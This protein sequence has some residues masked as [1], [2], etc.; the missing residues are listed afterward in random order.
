MAQDLHARLD[1]DQARF[2]PR[3]H[4]PAAEQETCDRLPMPAGQAAARNKF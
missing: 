1:L 2:K 4:D 3:Q